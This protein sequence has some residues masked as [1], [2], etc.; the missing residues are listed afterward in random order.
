MA[1]SAFGAKEARIREPREQVNLCGACGSPISASELLCKGCRGTMGRGGHRNT[2][3]FN[4][5]GASCER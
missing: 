3:D 2:P 4:A 5:D 1:R